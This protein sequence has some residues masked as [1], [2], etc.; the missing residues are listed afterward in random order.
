MP[1]INNVVVH[2]IVA[3][4]A[5]E[6]FDEANLRAKRRLVNAARK[7]ELGEIPDD[8]GVQYLTEDPGGGGGPCEPNK[9]VIEYTTNAGGLPEAQNGDDN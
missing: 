3:R 5:G 6:D 2:I 4:G 9:K 7:V 8:A 1:D